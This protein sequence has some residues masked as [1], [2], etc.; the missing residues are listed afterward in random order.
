V[1]FAL[2]FALAMLSPSGMGFGDVKLGALIAL[3]SGWIGYA[4]AA[5]A[6][7]AGFA[8]GGLVALGL[9]LSRR[10]GLRDAIP[11]GPAL[12]VGAWLVMVTR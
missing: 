5:M 6:I 9:V 4:A 2:L 12:L 1:V 11:M 7:A 8:V 3:F 10:R